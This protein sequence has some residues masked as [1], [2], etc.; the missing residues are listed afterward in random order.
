VFLEIVLFAGLLMVLNVLCFVYVWPQCATVHVPAAM[1]LKLSLPPRPLLAQLVDMN[2]GIKRSSV[3][4][5]GGLAKSSRSQSKVPCQQP[6]LLQKE[7]GVVDAR[8]NFCVILTELLRLDIIGIKHMTDATDVHRLQLTARILK[9]FHIARSQVVA[10]LVLDWAVRS[11]ELTAT[12]LVNLRD[13]VGTADVA[14]ADMCAIDQYRSLLNTKEWRSYWTGRSKLNLLKFA[15]TVSNHDLLVFGF[16]FEV[17]QK[18]MRVPAVLRH[19][20]EWTYMGP[21][22]SFGLLRCVSAAVGQKLRD[23]AAAATGM[24]SHTQHL[25]DAL[26]LPQLRKELRKLS[27]VRASDGL[28]GFYLCETA[29]LL[30]E[31]G[32]LKAMQLY[33]GNHRNLIKDLVGDAA[34]DFMLHLEEYGQVP[35]LSGAETAAQN[36]VMPDEFLIHQPLH[37]TTDTLKRWKAVAKAGSR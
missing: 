36:A 27:G 3:E 37:T 11:P 17:P 5:L 35:V 16:R 14:G 2:K 8:H 21:Y 24:S 19:I 15:K 22:L 9:S 7:R 26:G 12:F 23:A 30:K 1:W 6:K 20:T 10:I 4:K 33:E 18:Y 28:L 29:K 34:Q 32:V 25:A 13:G 31:T